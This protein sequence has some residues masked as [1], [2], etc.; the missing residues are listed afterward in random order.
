[1]LP[2]GEMYEGDFVKG[3]RHGAG[4]YITKE[5]VRFEGE[6]RGGIFMGEGRRFQP[7]DLK[8][9]QWMYNDLQGYGRAVATRRSASAVYE[10]HLHMS[11]Y[12]GPGTLI[13]KDGSAYRGDF[14]GGMK[15]GIG[16]LRK[17]NGYVYIG[18]WKL[19]TRDGVGR[20][21][22]PADGTTY[23]GEFFNDL[24]H[25]KGKMFDP[26]YGRS[27]GGGESDLGFHKDEF[28]EI[29]A[30]EEDA[31]ARGL[32]RAMSAERLK[33]LLEAEGSDGDGEGGSEAKEGG[34]GEEGQGEEGLAGDW[35]LPDPEWGDE[36][37]EIEEEEGE[38]GAAATRGSGTGRSR[39]S[40]NGSAMS[41]RSRRS[42]R[43]GEGTSR[44]GEGGDDGIAAVSDSYSSSSDSE[45]DSDASGM[46]SFF[47]KPKP[48]AKESEPAEASSGGDGSARQSDGG[49][50][51]KG[52]D[53]DE[54]GSEGRAALGE[55]G[56][57]G[58]EEEDEEEEED[59]Q[60]QRRQAEI[61]RLGN[62][63]NLWREGVWERGHVQKWTSQ[64]VTWAGTDEFITRFEGPNPLGLDS[65]LAVLI[66]RQLPQ[67]PNGV[68]KYN[69]KVRKEGNLS[70]LLCCAL[71]VTDNGI[72]AVCCCTAGSRHFKTHY[73]CKPGPC[74][75]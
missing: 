43:D 57:E 1:M 48:K 30:A 68:N 36:D 10:G 38:G 60:E 54:R 52:T 34:Q 45:S 75:C 73:G 72:G 62:T 12:H 71:A 69:L 11:R 40:G 41:G 53:G 31:I 55:G 8:E 39:G 14:K 37:K 65:T 42:T 2:S 20:E 74:S 59:V 50:E 3:K 4:I 29:E 67:V 56:K 28:E 63:E 27:M 47:R 18:D 26:E 49:V 22:D 21:R 25:G 46:A 6:W 66:A 16:E 15:H 23:E 9:G 33:S 7:G 64:P 5:G 51:S 58:K 35:A 17:K 70:L 19:N 32:V 61:L 13:D 24:R 44:D